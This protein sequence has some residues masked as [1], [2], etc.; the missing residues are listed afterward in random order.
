MK[1]AGDLDRYAPETAWL[2][3]KALPKAMRMRPERKKDG[4]QL[5]LPTLLPRKSIGQQ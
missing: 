2:I 1:E 5:P 4:D 3:L